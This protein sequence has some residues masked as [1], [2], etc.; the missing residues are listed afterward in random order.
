MLIF[1]YLLSTATP[2]YYAQE[3]DATVTINTDLLPPEEVPNLETFRSDLEYYINNSRFTDQEWEGVK[4]PVT[5]A[6]HFTSG[7]NGR[8]AAQLHITAYRYIGESL[9]HRSPL[10]Q[11]TDRY[12][13]FQ[14]RPNTI[15]TYQPNRFD[16][17]SS[18]ID[19]YMLLIIGADGD[20]YAELGGTPHYQAAYRIWELGNT[21]QYPGF[22][23]STE[24]GEFSKYQM[25][26]EYTSP[27]F[28]EFRKLIFQYYADG[29]DLLIEN[30]TQ[31]QRNIDAILSQ[32]VRWKHRLGK[33]S[34]L[35][36]L[37]FDTH[38]QELI[39]IFRD[40]PSRQGVIR[41][42]QFLDPG[43]SLD[44]EQLLHE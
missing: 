40:Y 18:L 32:M 1:L 36:R 14:Y 8:Y 21:A 16:P 25:V 30:R 6:V 23:R 22:E 24:L 20:S 39:D 41:K 43:H 37:F 35:L 28:E 38:T 3:I 27:E 34:I 42:L 26:S 2:S 44:Y 29:I 33:P 31:A 13:A 10:V 7:S 11:F 5:I 9:Q 19:F 15:L 17:L 12:W 4:I